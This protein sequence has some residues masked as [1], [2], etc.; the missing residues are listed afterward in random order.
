MF[1]VSSYRGYLRRAYGGLMPASSDSASQESKP[2]RQ[3][4]PQRRF[5][6]SNSSPLHGLFGFGSGDDYYEKKKERCEFVP[7]HQYGGIGYGYV[8]Y[9]K[10]YFIFHMI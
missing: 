8:K 4:Q 10:H 9:W 6:F 3:Q 1:D 5:F 7:Y 2:P